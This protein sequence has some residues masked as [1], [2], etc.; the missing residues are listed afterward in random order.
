[1]K[2]QPLKRKKNI[3]SILEP[4]Y[5]I[6][7]ILFSIAVFFSLATSATL[8]VVQ[9]HNHITN[10]QTHTDLQT[11]KT[12]LSQ[13]GSQLE[14]QSI[15]ISSLQTKIQKLEASNKQ[16]TDIFYLLQSYYS[17]QT[18]KFSL[19]ITKDTA[20]AIK[21]LSSAEENLAHSENPSIVKIRNSINQD[22]KSLQNV[23]DNGNVIQVT[24]Q[25][26]TIQQKLS[27]LSSLSQ[28][29][30]ELKEKIPSPTAIT[31]FPLSLWSSLWQ[32]SLLILKKAVIIREQQQPLNLLTA[33]Q[34]T[35]LLL[36]IQYKLEVAK[37]ALLH[38]Q[39]S[40]YRNNLQQVIDTLHSYQLQIIPAELSSILNKL[41]ELQKFPSS[42][43]FPNLETSEKLLET[44]IIQ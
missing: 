1:M 11:T 17:L 39:N 2:Q 15:T 5:K 10:E 3:P 28:P 14:Q 13:T 20:A 42:S 23:G 25:L 16:K 26:E 41:Q 22:L 24:S 18:A 44:A 35:D 21:F 31:K 29:K 12:S 32:N 8:L 33:D 19:I 40:I 37:W 27:P 7:F 36:N 6:F 38:N 9:I 4:K 43:V 30:I 34:R